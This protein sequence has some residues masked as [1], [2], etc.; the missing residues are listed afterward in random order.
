MHDNKEIELV[1]LAQKGDPDAREQLIA[2]HKTFI[3]SSCYNIC[4][5]KIS[6]GN[7]EELSVALLAFNE[8]ISAYKPE[9]GASLLTFARQLINQRLIDFFRREK[10]HHHLPLSS[11]SE[12]ED[13]EELS[14]V[15]CS[16][17]WENYKLQTEKDELAE[18][19]LEYD[20][21]LGE[22]GTS[23][24]ELA[25]VS[26]K[27]KDTRE[28]LLNV[29]R[30]L[31]NNE[32]FLSTFLKN[33]RIPVKDL[34]RAAKVSRRVLE[35]GRKYIIALAIIIS[36]GKFSHLRSFAGLDD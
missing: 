18:I 7:D 6:W 25:D 1:N 28:K 35:N 26:P 14:K 29:A 20:H 36:E 3:Y 17:A 22:Y 13:K 19:M 34:S 5:R 2:Q 31:C 10:R 11:I 21:V 27:H 32:D 15:E 33:K 16:Q 30:L 9:K 24:E 23:L 12:D 8:A 4:K